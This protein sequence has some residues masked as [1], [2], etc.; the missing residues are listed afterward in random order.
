MGPKSYY[1]AGSYDGRA[2]ELRIETDDERGVLSIEV[3]R[4]GR[5]GPK[6]RNVFFSAGFLAVQRKLGARLSRWLSEF[7]GRGDVNVLFDDVL[8]A[9]ALESE[10]FV[11]EISPRDWVEID[12]P[13]DLK[14][15]EEVF[16]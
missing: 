3:L 15:A 14:R 1:F 4:G 16:R 9:H 6:G 2:N 5:S 13:E 8:A 12:T 10:L 7:A 11:Y